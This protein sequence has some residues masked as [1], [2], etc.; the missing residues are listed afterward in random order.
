MAI[1]VAAVITTGAAWNGP[2]LTILDND[3]EA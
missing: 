3:R 1:D 2:L